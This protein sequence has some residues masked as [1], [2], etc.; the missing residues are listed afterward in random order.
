MAIDTIAQQPAADSL[1]VN[2]RPIILI[3]TARPGS[4]AGVPPVVYCDIYIAGQYYKSLSKSI[5]KE[6][7]ESMGDTYANFEFDIQDA[8]QEYLI[9]RPLVNGGFGMLG[10]SNYANN[11][12]TYINCLCEFRS[13]HLDADGFIVVE[14]TA[15]VQR[16]ATALPEAGVG[17][18]SN[19]FYV[20][21]ATLQHEENQNFLTH[22]DYYLTN[23]T[24]TT[25][26]A[27]IFGISPLTH[28]PLIY[29]ICVGD[30]DYY[31]FVD[32]SSNSYT[33]IRLNYTDKEG[34]G[35]YEEH[36]YTKASGLVQWISAGPKNLAAAFPTVDFNNVREYYIEVYNEPGNVIFRTCLYTIGCCCLPDKVR[37]HFGNHMGTTDAINFADYRVV[38]DN[39]SSNWKKANSIPLTKQSTG[40]NRFNVRANDIYECSTGCYSEAEMRWCMEMLNSPVA[41]IEWSGTEGQSD[42]FLPVVILDAKF[43]R[44]KMYERYNM[45][46]VVQFKM[47]N[48]KIIIR[49]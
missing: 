18:E 34:G 29:K 1:N 4:S 8:L 23:N 24:V 45:E 5:A 49:N 13:S 19:E 38:N 3:A 33:K 26:V 37:L 30:S 9:Y 44:R 39:S 14:G 46:L 36:S 42:D 27:K 16:T 22:L 12:D 43:E 17:Y 15:P 7:I 31:P 20:F 47:A 40:I 2:Y 28:R 41:F 21:N 6:V 35:F 32:T 25:G 48:E 11:A 10:A